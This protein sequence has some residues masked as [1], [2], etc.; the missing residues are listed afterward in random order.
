MSDTLK[1]LKRPR[2][3]WMGSWDILD[4]LDGFKKE[5]PV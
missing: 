3:R 2:T 1:S 5:R 4:I